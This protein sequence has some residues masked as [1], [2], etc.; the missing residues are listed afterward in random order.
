M[1]KVLGQLSHDLAAPT[2]RTEGVGSAA[3]GFLFVS[4]VC[5]V[6]TSYCIDPVKRVK[7]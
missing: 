4:L 3:E 7:L 2:V 6:V 5:F 1:K